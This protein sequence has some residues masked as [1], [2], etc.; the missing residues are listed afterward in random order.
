MSE[1]WQGVNIYWPQISGEGLEWYADTVTGR[2]GV[3]VGVQCSCGCYWIKPFVVNKPIPLVCL[4][5]TSGFVWIKQTVVHMPIPLV[6]TV[7]W[8][9]VWSG[10]PG[11]EKGIA[12]LLGCREWGTICYL[13]LYPIS[14]DHELLVYSVLQGYIPSVLMTSKSVNLF[15]LSSVHFPSFKP[16]SFFLSLFFQFLLSIL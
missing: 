12:N 13:F 8:V 14:W 11:D 4:M 6:C 1:A 5:S 2:E 3:S 10:Y 16:L 7:H 9:S 15:S